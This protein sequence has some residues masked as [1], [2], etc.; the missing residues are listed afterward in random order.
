LDYDTLAGTTKSEEEQKSAAAAASEA[1]EMNGDAATTVG[2][3]YTPPSHL[4]DY[5]NSS[6]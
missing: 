5:D 2:K 4:F 6:D 3:P 1:Q